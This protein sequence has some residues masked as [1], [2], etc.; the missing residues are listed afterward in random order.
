MSDRPTYPAVDPRRVSKLR[1][2]LL[3]DIAAMAPDWRG[4]AE[5]TGPD[6]AVVEAG[7]RLSEEATKRLDRTPER[8]ALAFLDM[9]NIAPPDPRAA[10]GVIVFG[11]KEDQ[12]R[13]VL[14]RARTGIEITALDGKAAAFETDWDLSLQ[15]A[16]IGRLVTLDPRA[17]RIELA[18]DAVTTLEPDTVPRPTYALVTA[19]GPDDAAMLLEPPIGIAEGDLLRIGAEDDPAPLYARVTEFRDDGL[20]D[21]DAPL[22]INLDPG[23]RVERMTRLD[24]FM[25]PNAQ[26]HAL[27]IGD[28]QVLNVKE[29]AEITLRFDPAEAAALLMA[30]NV[31]FEAY[32]ID[33]ASGDEEPKWLELVPLGAA[34][35]TITLFK[36]WTGPLSEWKVGEHEGLWLRIVPRAPILPDGESGILHPLTGPE[37][38]VR[39]I[40][41]GLKTEQPAPDAAEDTISQVAHNGLPLSRASSF[42]PFGPE[43][44][45]FD[46]FALAAPEVFTKPGARVSLN[47]TLLDATLMTLAA[48]HRFDEYRHLYGIGRNGRLQAVDKSRAEPL[49]KEF[50]GP[51]EDEN[52]EATQALDPAFGIHAFG[53]TV[54]D[55]ITAND[56]V[57]VR[58]VAGGLYTA[59]VTYEPGQA[60]TAPE[61]LQIDTWQSLPGLSDG[62]LEDDEVPAMAIAPRKRSDGVVDGYLVFLSA[63]ATLFF[64]LSADGVLN[65]DTWKTRPGFPETV[66]IPQLSVVFDPSQADAANVNTDPMAKFL[67]ADDAGGVWLF[68]A[69]SN[70]GDWRRLTDAFGDLEVDP[71][72]RPEGRIYRFGAAQSLRMAVA[73]IR[74][75]KFRIWDY[76][77]PNAGPVFQRRVTDGGSGNLDPSTRIGI[78][79]GLGPTSTSLPHVVGF[80]KDAGGI[81]L[82]EWAPSGQTSD[83]VPLDMQS[84]LVNVTPIP[85]SYLPDDTDA[86]AALSVFGP[87]A[88]NKQAL[89]ML[90]GNSQSVLQLPVGPSIRAELSSWVRSTPPPEDGDEFGQIAILRKVDDGGG[91]DAPDLIVVP[92]TSIGF[93]HPDDGADIAALDHAEWEDSNFNR[94]LS[95]FRLAQS[96]SGQYRTGGKLKANNPT[97]SWF[98]GKQV[99]IDPR[100]SLPNAAEFLGPFTIVSVPTDDELTLSPQDAATV[101]AVLG[102]TD[103]VDWHI[104][105]HTETLSGDDAERRNQA[106]VRNTI[107]VTGTPERISAFTAPQQSA[108]LTFLNPHATDGPYILQA[109]WAGTPPGDAEYLKIRLQN[110]AAPILSAASLATAYSNPELSWEYFDGDGWR[111][112]GPAER[113][114]DKTADFAN[115]GEIAFDVPDR[116]TASEIG[117]QED[118]WI[119]ARLVGGDY[120]RPKYVVEQTDDGNGNITQEVVVST[121]HMRPPEISRVTASV[122]LDPVHVPQLVV[123]RNNLRDLDQSSA[124]RRL[125]TRYRLFYGAFEPP[126]V[127]GAQA[128]TGEPD[129]DRLGRAMMVGFTHPLSLGLTTLFVTSAD[130]EQAH[131]LELSTLGPDGDWSAAP[132]TEEDPTQGFNRT[133]LLQFSVSERPAPVRLFGQTLHWL[134]IRAVGGNAATWMPRLRGMWL[135][136]VAVRQSET[137]LHEPLGSSDGEPGQQV[138]LLKTRILPGSLDLRVRE[139]LGSEEVAAIRREF[140]PDTVLDDVPNLPGQWVRWRRVASF[141]DQDGAARVYLAS[142]SGQVTFGDGQFGRLPLAGRDNLRAFSYQAG[143][144][145]L[146]TAD[147]ADAGIRGS[148]EGLD[149]VLSPAAIAGGRDLPGR[150][151]LVARMPQVLRHAGQGLS[152]S[153]VEAMARDIDSEIV[154]VRAFPPD[155]TR[156]GVL[157][158][159]LARGEGRQPVYSL[160][161]RDHLKRELSAAMSDAWPLSCLDVQSVGFAA[162]VATVMLVAEPGRTATVQSEAKALLDLFLDPARGGPDGAGWPPGRPV[163]PN[164]IRRALAGLPGLGR[165]G[166]ISIRRRDGTPLDDVGPTQVV[167]ATRSR[168]V[169]VRLER[170]GET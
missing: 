33:E 152:L 134:R 45:R 82:I 34:G 161:R 47:F 22:G 39:Q 61:A 109:G 123:A 8:D 53:L 60:A 120:G 147:F 141:A 29:P 118:Y 110:D 95:V 42:L 23:T 165:I 89:I 37:A 99:L 21:L 67:A 75:G 19:T 143:G 166:E 55:G 74:D 98:P 63:S 77:V 125:Q 54:S 106:L 20:T 105:Q 66:T 121:D 122:H 73:G 101:E 13:P 88:T 163:W 87:T 44:Q 139:R 92:D 81:S 31:R 2:A 162:V 100:P 5:E 169:V 78:I 80:R 41:L 91:G 128:D 85:P 168:D 72:S 76:T 160:A 68:E 35:E 153:D 25:M 115:T 156:D 119:R 131:K 148:L 94:D 150:P 79:A 132:L 113:F 140:G 146:E 9:F 83:G 93:T 124:N 27:Y 90:A 40:T 151:E 170:A 4:A 159:V 46:A 155:A 157:V 57:V 137:I 112:L 62:T 10:E 24:A 71:G 6:R 136:G 49:W 14:A 18:P 149:V 111:R 103:P 167:A 11:L 133:G 32:G 36:P 70:D 96:H 129:R 1:E 116:L 51:P 16:R 43:P 58:T 48:A 117:G 154:Q 102:D 145:R 84:G 50:A 108:A 7:A 142:A 97:S 30:Q 17:D 56:R 15:P 107:G 38:A 138:Q 26:E 3:R 114:V 158:S 130:Q 126:M 64:R 135:N 164:D 127:D 28:A 12:A 59:V 69:Q 144:I 86:I 52:S 104:V 65:A